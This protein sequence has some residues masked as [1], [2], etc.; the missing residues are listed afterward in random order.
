MEKKTDLSK[1]KVI[2][3]DKLSSAQMMAFVFNNR[4]KNFFEN[5]YENSGYLHFSS[6]QNVFN[7]TTN[8]CYYFRKIYIVIYKYFEFGALQSSIVW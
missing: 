7:L 8:K 3:A 1:S 4:G 6:F 5:I 2:A